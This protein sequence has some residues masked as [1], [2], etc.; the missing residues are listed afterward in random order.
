MLLERDSLGGEQTLASQGMIHGGLKYAL[1]GTLTRS[2][3]AIANMPE[4]WRACR[5]HG[6][7]GPQRAHSAVRSLLH[8]C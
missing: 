7:G 3:E 6:R 2:S 4:R 5:R 8:V 1:G